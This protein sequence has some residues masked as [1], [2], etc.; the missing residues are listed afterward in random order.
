MHI[1]VNVT[2][3]Q[4]IYSEMKIE[5]LLDTKDAVSAYEEQHD[6]LREQ[7]DTQIAAV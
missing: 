7:Q 5:F 3:V 1:H 2:V 6:A 4:R